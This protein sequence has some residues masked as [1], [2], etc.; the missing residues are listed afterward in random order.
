MST[1]I[2]KISCVSNVYVRQMIFEKVGD[3]ERPHDH[4]FDHQTLLAKG[5]LKL[6]IGETQSVFV[7]PQIIFIKAGVLHDLVAL[8]DDTIAYCIH[9]LRDGDD[10]CDIIDPS[11]VPHGINPNRI[12][13]N[14]KPLTK[15]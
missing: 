6:T 13:D 15:I 1:P 10:V 11:G 12:W 3:A 2:T 9:A 7:A 5:A 4:V 14:A 8:E